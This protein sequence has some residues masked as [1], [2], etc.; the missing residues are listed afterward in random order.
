MLNFI[1]KKLNEV[2]LTSCD[3]NSQIYANKF[4]NILELFNTLF[5]RLQFD[6]I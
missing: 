5:I 2:T 1:Y 6:E 3:N 4:V